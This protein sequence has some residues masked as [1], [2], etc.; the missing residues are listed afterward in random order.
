MMVMGKIQSNPLIQLCQVGEC[1]I[2]CLK[3]KNPQKYRLNLWGNTTKEP[4]CSPAS[5]QITHGEHLGKEMCK[6]L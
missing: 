2:Q 5:Q 1:K 6:K 4:K 3:K